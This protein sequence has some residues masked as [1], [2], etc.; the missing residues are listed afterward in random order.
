M[1]GLFFKRAL[2]PSGW[3]GD[4][5]VTIA[6]GRFATVTPDAAP[7]PGD[8]RH[9]VAFPGLANVHSHA[10]QRGFTGLTEW[11]WQSRDSFWTWR[12]AMYRFALQLH[13]GGMRAIAA[14]AHAEA[15]EA[16]YT[17]VGE[18]HYLHHGTD[19]QPYAVPAEIAAHHGSRRGHR[20]CPDPSAGVLGLRRLRPGPSD[21]GAAAFPAHARRL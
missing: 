21:Q 18:F 1:T 17:R 3:A 7:E 15:L 6:D 8:G 20:H 9:A 19:G 14:L 12:E 5:R 16:G 13:P 10:F 2:L 4:V 11:R